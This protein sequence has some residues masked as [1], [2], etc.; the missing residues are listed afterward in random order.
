M[1]ENQ[2]PSCSCCSGKKTLR[3]EE[4]KKKLLNRLKRIEGQIRGIQSML[5]KDSYCNDILT[6]SGGLVQRRAE[7]FQ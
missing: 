7:Q 1:E 4:E 2:K 5:E 3:E 6:Q